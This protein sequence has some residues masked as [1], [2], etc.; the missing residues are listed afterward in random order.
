MNRQNLSASIANG[1]VGQQKLTVKMNYG[2]MNLLIGTGHVL[3]WAIMI[4]FLHSP[5]SILWKG[6]VLILFCLM[7]QGVFSVMHECFHDQG[8]PTS[9]ANWTLGVIEGT[10]FGT[11]YTLFRVNHEAHHVRNR[12]R[13]EIAEYI[14]PDESPT[15]KILLYY[16]AILGG[17]WLGAFV[18][19]IL[20]PFIPY[21]YRLG[22][23]RPAKSM[24]GY[25]LAFAEFSSR[26]WM[27]LR[28]EA[29]VGL[30]VWVSAIL[31]LDWN[32]TVL[33]VAYA[34]FA[35]TWSSLQWIYHLRTPLDR[36]EG[37]Y[38]LRAP[39]LVRWLFLNFNYNLTHHRHPAAPWQDAH[40]LTDLKETQPLWYRYLLIFRCPEP[41]PADLSSI[42]KTYF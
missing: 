29:A 10:I 39:L 14:F 34:A 9:W 41:L 16:F 32:W 18:A 30:L 11:A 15:R 25:F 23:N 13:A 3:A 21:R 40:A 22:L 38:N 12:S 17:I 24:N 5:S 36:V 8:H 1:G 37:A 28:V 35:F 20:L 7:M 6:V 2:T 26:D 31:L 19:S 4:S 33:S 27:R 42:R